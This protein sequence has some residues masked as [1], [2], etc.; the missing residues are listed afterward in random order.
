MHKSENTSHRRSRGFTLVEL[1]V[2]IGII[3]V[4]VAMLLPALN[5][6]RRAAQSV[7]CGSNLRQLLIASRMYGNDN[8]DCMPAY[9]LSTFTGPTVWWQT[10]AKYI[11]P[12]GFLATTA[13]QNKVAVYNCPSASNDLWFATDAYPF[14]WNLYPVTYEISYYSSDAQPY[15]PPVTTHV[16]GP[17]FNFYQYTKFSHWSSS[18]FILF[19]DSLPHTFWVQ[20]LARKAYSP[21][22]GRANSDLNFSLSA[23]FYHGSGNNIIAA[24]K[25]PARANVVFLDGHVESLSAEELMRFHLSPDNAKRTYGLNG[26]QGDPNQLP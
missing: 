4:L 14:W 26:S 5:K 8:K 24:R 7:A 18:S 1:L 11:A 23:A 13:T 19:A 12:K 16:S 3:A 22:I 6:A 17:H 20:R 9:D 15:I 21:Y 10:L 2:V 25:S